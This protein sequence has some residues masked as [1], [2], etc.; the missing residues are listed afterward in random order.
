VPDEQFDRIDVTGWAVDRDET[1]GVEEKMWLIEPDTSPPV[2]WLFKSVTVSERDAC[3]ED[4]A[5]KAAAELGARLGIPCATVDLAGRDGRRGSVAA[6]L[7]PKGCQMQPGALLM[8]D[9]EVPGYIPRARGRPGHSLENIRFVLDGVFPPPGWEFPFEATG[10]DV[11][12]GFTMFDALIANRDR[13]DENWAVL[14]P[15]AGEGPAMLCGSYDHANS[16]GYNL[17][18]AKREMYLGRENGVEGWCRKGTAFR[19]E[20]TPGKKPPTLVQTAVR[21]LGLASEAALEHWSRRLELLGEAEIRSVIDDTERHRPA[22]GIVG[23]RAY[24]YNRGSASESEEGARCL[25]MTCWRSR[26]SPGTG[27]LRRPGG[28]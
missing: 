21:A 19:F 14:L 5:E 26:A 4:L 7:R 16:L 25:C 20:H 17:T 24:L 23:T 8:L 13:H 2:S 28:S 10:F 11:F 18:D 22:A 27:P 6:D 1:S 15:V 12:A 3:C 9:R